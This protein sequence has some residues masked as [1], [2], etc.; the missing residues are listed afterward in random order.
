MNPVQFCTCF[1]MFHASQSKLELSGVFFY[2]YP[3]FNLTLYDPV[4]N[5]SFLSGQAFLG[6]TRTKQ[7]LMSVKLK[8]AILS[9]SIQALYHCAT[10]LSC[11]SFKKCCQHIFESIGK[12]Q[13][14]CICIAVKL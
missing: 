10:V 4:N 12:V 13:C 5:V 8:H 11:L 2:V 9:I 7:G 14:V 1:I 3:T 6:K